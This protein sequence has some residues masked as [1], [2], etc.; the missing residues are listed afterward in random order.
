M[1]FKTETKNIDRMAKHYLINNITPEPLHSVGI[2]SFC[3]N[4][5]LST[6]TNT[7]ILFFFV[8]HQKQ[9]LQSAV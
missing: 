4:S 2:G 6:H 3:A 8:S 1:I 5:S 7:Q 9:T